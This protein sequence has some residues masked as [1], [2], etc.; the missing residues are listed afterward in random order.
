MT[1]K[2]VL[3][4]GNIPEKKCNLGNY[5]CHFM[6]SKY[7]GNG[8]GHILVDGSLNLLLLLRLLSWLFKFELFLSVT[9]VRFKN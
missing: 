1:W 8:L 3:L 2:Q 7:T 6:L 9:L 4:L 5:S